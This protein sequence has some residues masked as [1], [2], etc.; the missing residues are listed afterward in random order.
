MSLQNPVFLITTP[1][2]DDVVY[3]CATWSKEIIEEADGRS[4]NV[5]ELEKSKANRGNLEGHLKKQ[6]PRFLMFNGH[7]D[8]NAIYGYKNEPLLQKGKDEHLM[9]GTITYARSCF[10]LDGLGKSCFESGA[11]AFAGYSLPFTFV[12]DPVRSANPLKDE[13]A[14]PCFTSSNI[15][16]LSLIKGANISEAVQKA[17]DE[18]DKLIGY[19]ETR[20]DR[21]EAQFVASCLYWNKMGLGF[22]GEASAK[23]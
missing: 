14:T 7:G 4:F 23:L 16:P 9:K 5:V 1:D 11:E 8:P 17:K 18:M 21:I 10:S 15:I 19:W 22:H 13:L 12:S 2:H 6:R 20:D 3:Y